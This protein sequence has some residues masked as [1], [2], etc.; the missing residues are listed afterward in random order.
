MNLPKFVSLD[1][2]L[3]EGIVADLF[4]GSS[5]SASGHEALEASI[6]S[7][8]RAQLLQDTEP[9]VAKVL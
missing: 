3:F 4:P 8:A 6:R 1:I 2:P 7:E 5:E 9:F